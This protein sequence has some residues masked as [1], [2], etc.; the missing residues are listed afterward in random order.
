MIRMNPSGIAG[1]HARWDC[2]RVVQAADLRPDRDFLIIWHSAGQEPAECVDQLV[3]APNA[4]GS[5]WTWLPCSSILMS[6][7][8]FVR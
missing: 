4:P 2:S 5:M 1:A 6:A 7:G 8:G 3:R